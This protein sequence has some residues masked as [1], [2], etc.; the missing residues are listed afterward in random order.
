MM[1]FNSIFVDTLVK[2]HQEDLR[3]AGRP[4]H[5]RNKVSAIRKAVGHFLVWLGERVGGTVPTPVRDSAA[6]SLA[7]VQS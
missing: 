1:Q 4:F 3:K 7:V 2:A 5:I 6:H